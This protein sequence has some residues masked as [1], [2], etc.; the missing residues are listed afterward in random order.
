[1][2]RRLDLRRGPGPHAG[3]A[4]PDRARSSPRATSA[5][6]GPLGPARGPGRG[7]RPRPRPGRRPHPA[8]LRARP[9]ASHAPRVQLL[10]DGTNSNTATVAQRLR[11]AHRAGVRAARTAASRARRPSSC[12]SAPGSTP[13]LKSRDYNVPAVM[14]QI[15][16]HPEPA[17]DLARR[18]ARA[19]AG[20]ARAA[21]GEPAHAGRADRRQD[22]ALRAHRPRRTW[23]SSPT[24]ALLWFHV[25]FEGS[26]L[27]LLAG[28]R[29][30]PALAR[31]GSGC[32]SR[33]SRTPSRRPC[34]TTL[35]HHHAAH[36]ALRLHV[37]G[38]QHAGRR[39][40]GSRCSTRCGTS[41]RSCAPSSSR[42]PGSDALW[43][44]FLA[45]LV[46]GA[47]RAGL[48]HDALPQDG[49]LSG[50]ACGTGKRGPGR[51]RG[52]RARRARDGGAAAP[53]GPEIRNRPTDPSPGGA[54]PAREV[55]AVGARRFYLI[56]YGRRKP[57]LRSPR[58]GQRATTGPAQGRPS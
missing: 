9:R 27:L 3:L 57:T 1:M 41:S 15:M 16:L 37:P 11:R 5:S 40:S 8:R 28:G 22:R 31:S 42:A 56:P 19:R 21:H 54:W 10:L 7:P 48:R 18:G 13:A 49:A 52:G 50:A 23:C 26:F 43:P 32:S 14:G 4:R 34:M 25:P 20:H 2:R 33:P 36:P 44:Q 47:G 35:P 46:M 29:A 17:A 39:S 55:V 58:A 53:C 45:L 30:L 12:A 24:V 6:V 38:E 51:T